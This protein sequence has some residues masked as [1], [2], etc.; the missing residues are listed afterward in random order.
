MRKTKTVT[1]DAE[2][3]DKGK[4]YLITEMP[5]SQAESWAMRAMSAMSRSGVA[6][7]DEVMAGGI[8]AFTMVGLR[9][10]MAA[11]WADVG[12]LLDELMG[13][14]QRVEPAITRSLVESDI[15]DI[16][17]RMR[18]R[19]EVLQLHVGFSL[20][21]V[22][23]QAVAPLQTQNSSATPISATPSEPSLAVE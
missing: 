9:A 18:L 2:G 7:P 6:I 15:E 21:A 22:L 12:P 14:V 3:R 13:C 11:P 20:A 23:F 16:G 4:S 1:I 5:A 8:V 19:D 10:F 17:T